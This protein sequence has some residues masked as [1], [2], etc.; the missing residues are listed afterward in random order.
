V[1]LREHVFRGAL[2]RA[3]GGCRSVLDV[4]C[5]AASPLAALDLAAFTIGLDR[6]R[7]DLASARA[8]RTHRALVCADASSVDSLFASRS[9]DAV[10]ALD[11]IEHLERDAGIA[12]VGRLERVAR[13][14]VVVFTPN[15]FV[16]QPGTAENPWQEHRAGF[17]ADDMRRLGYRVRGMHGLWFLFGAF[18]ACRMRPAALWRRVADVTAPGVYFVPSLAFG[19]LCVKDVSGSGS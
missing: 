2:R 4:G 18:G 11:V 8:A 19:L 3:L 5:G 12:L 7:P 15:G 17:S 9:I 1:P 10:V 6:C 13:R 14:R 16:P